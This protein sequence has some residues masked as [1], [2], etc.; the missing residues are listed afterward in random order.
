MEIQLQGIQRVWN[1]DT[2]YCWTVGVGLCGVYG[3]YKLWSVLFIPGFGPWAGTANGSSVAKLATG[4]TFCSI[5][6]ARSTGWIVEGATISTPFALGA[7]CWWCVHVLRVS[8][9]LQSID[10]GD[11]A[12]SDVL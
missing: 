1:I 2:L 6:W 9:M 5:C 8:A 4:I 7:L 3:M 12:T 10:C 11:L